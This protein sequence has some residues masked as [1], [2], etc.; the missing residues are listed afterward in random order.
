MP[1]LSITGSQTAIEDEYAA[2]RRGIARCAPRDV[3]FDAR[4]YA[5]EAVAEARELWRVRMRAEHDSVS[6][7]TG[8]TMRLLEAHG[9]LDAEAVMLRMA[10]D[11]V[12]HA[13]LCGEAV[14][15]LGGDGTCEVAAEPQ[16]LPLHPGC[17]PEERALRDVLYGCCL[18]ETMNTAQLV[19]QLDCTADPYLH[20]RTRLLLADEVLHGSFG[21]EY[22][23]AWAPWLDA[24]PAARTSIEGFLRHAFAFLE[25]ARAGR[26]NTPRPLS[27]DQLAL[28]IS[29]PMRV[30]EVFIQTIEGAILPALERFGLDASTAWR[31]RRLDG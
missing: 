1:I 15:A 11:E 12:R 31:E 23:A 10:A 21:Y 3:A 18:V 30:P 6:V 29:D 24:H 22:L 5:P 16:R 26:G 28:G 25:H 4:L 20:E 7:F 2:L 14:R 17:G 27:A 8:M 19:D 13:E 9:T